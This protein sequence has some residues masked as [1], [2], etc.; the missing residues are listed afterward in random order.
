MGGGGS[1]NSMVRKAQQALSDS[2][3]YSGAVDG[4]NGPRTEAA[5]SDFQ[6][7]MGL[8]ANGKLD[9]ATMK[10]IYRQ[11]PPALIPPGGATRPRYAPGMG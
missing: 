5:I 11:T 4:V 6:S 9:V 3:L 2:G 10:A 7:Q 8:D 1:G